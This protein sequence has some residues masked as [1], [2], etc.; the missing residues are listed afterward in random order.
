[1]VAA[2]SAQTDLARR[3]RERVRSRL[4]LGRIGQPEDVAALVAFLL[5]DEAKNMTGSIITTDGG[6]TAG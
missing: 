6:W 3:E 2:D 1:M 4:L 5:S